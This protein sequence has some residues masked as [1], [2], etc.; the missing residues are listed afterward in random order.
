MFTIIS[1]YYHYYLFTKL[2]PLFKEFLIFMKHQININKQ[3]EEH[4]K[5]KD[6]QKKKH[7]MRKKEIMEKT[8]KKIKE[9]YE[10]KQKK[11]NEIDNKYKTLSAQ[12]DSIKDPDELKK[13]FNDFIINN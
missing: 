11:I 2:Q 8:E 7:E 10:I 12:L 1:L 5:K 4:R 3:N 9:I 13:F 6:E